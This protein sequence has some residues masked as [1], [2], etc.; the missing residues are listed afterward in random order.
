MDFRLVILKVFTRKHQLSL[1]ADA[2][3]LLQQI[4]TDHE[5][6]NTEDAIQSLEILAKEYLLQDD[7]STIVTKP[8][9]QRV[10][11]TVVEKSTAAVTDGSQSSEIWDPDHHLYFI[12]AFEMP[13]WH[14]SLERKAFEKAI[15]K[16]NIAGSAESKAMFLRDRYNIIKQ[17]ILRNENFSPPAFAGKDRANYLKLTS[18]KN[19]LGRAGGRFLLFGML[20]RSPEGRLCL[21]DLDG[22]VPLNISNTGPSE[23]LFTEGCFVLVEGDYNDDGVLDVIA[24]GHPPSE[25]RA[26]ARSIY[27]HIDFLGKGATTVLQDDNWILQAQRPENANITILFISDVRLDDERTLK[28]LRTLFEQAVDADVIPKIFVFC[29]NFTGTPVGNDI[30]MDNY[31]DSF[32]ALGDLVAEF[33]SIRTSSHFLFVPGPGDPWSSDVLPRRPIPPAFINRLQ[34]KLSKRAIFATNPCRVKFMGQEIV[35]YRHDLMGKMMRNLV[36]VKPDLES[37]DLKR[38]LVQTILDQ[39]HLSPLAL[40]IQATSW[41]FDHALR[42]YPM[43]TAVVLADSYEPYELTYEGCHVFNPGSF[44]TNNYGFSTFYMATSRSMPGGLQSFRI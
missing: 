21:E 40:T 42:L 16:P 14:Y 41:E 7:C 2:M 32:T 44:L 38:Y 10:Y 34:A 27:G 33:P 37:A 9:L 35:I 11:E 39:V 22:I 17:I 24:I 25:R 23:G 15:Q 8:L 12:D 43:P 29:G 1:Q 26:T 19:L 4:L 18:T 28:G 20:T 5:I 30:E 31:K 3:T 13:R 36:G 6:T